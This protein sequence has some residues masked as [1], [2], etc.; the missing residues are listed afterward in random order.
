[1]QIKKHIMYIRHH[2][3]CSDFEKDTYYWKIIEHHSPLRV[4]DRYSADCDYL[5]GGSWCDD[6]GEWIEKIEQYSPQKIVELG[7]EKC[8]QGNLPFG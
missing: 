6:C 8:L 4:G 7:L 2:G 1:M 5:A 3:C